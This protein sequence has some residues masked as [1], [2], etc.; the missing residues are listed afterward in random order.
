MDRE[1]LRLQAM[2]MAARLNAPTRDVASCIETANKIWAWVES[3]EK[4]VSKTQANVQ[5]AVARLD[6]ESKPQKTGV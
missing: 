3:G 4:P 2:E 5:K 6:G 1:A